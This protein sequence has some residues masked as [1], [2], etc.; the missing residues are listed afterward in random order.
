MPIL[1][2]ESDDEATVDYGDDDAETVDY[3]GDKAGDDY[4]DHYVYDWWD[5]FQ[6]LCC[7][8]NIDRNHVL[9]VAETVRDSN[10]TPAAPVETAEVEFD[11]IMFSRIE[12]FHANIGSA[13]WFHVSVGSSVPRHLIFIVELHQGLARQVG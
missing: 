2:Q 9:N 6:N 4:H 8:M 11:D 13:I 3:G 1:A 5:S 7:R 10:P 12:C